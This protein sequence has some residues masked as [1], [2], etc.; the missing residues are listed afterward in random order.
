MTVRKLRT[1]LAEVCLGAYTSQSSVYEGQRGVHGRGLFR[2]DCLLDR[3][4][5]VL[6]TYTTSCAREQECCIRPV[7]AV[8]AVS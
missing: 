7:R 2:R 3:R 5:E 8:A 6:R 4:I 1:S